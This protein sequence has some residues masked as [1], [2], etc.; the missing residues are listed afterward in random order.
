MQWTYV[1]VDLS[2]NISPT[3]PHVWQQAWCNT[4]SSDFCQ[5][6]SF[7]KDREVA[8]TL[9]NAI[10]LVLPFRTVSAPAGRLLL[11]SMAALAACIR[12]HSMICQVDIIDFYVTNTL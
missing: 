12:K 4:P 5:A 9:R 10:Q 7:A 6:M 3:S 11:S 2:C 1:E 8:C